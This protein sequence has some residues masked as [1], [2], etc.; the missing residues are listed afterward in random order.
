M[1]YI[2]KSLTGPTG[3][4][5]TC[6]RGIRGELS[7]QNSTGTLTLLGFKDSQALVGN[8][9]S[10]DCR[11]VTI[12]LSGLPNWSAFHTAFLSSV[13][14]V[15][16]LLAGGVPKQ[17][18]DPVIHYVECDLTAPTGHSS[19]VWT[20]I[21]GHI[22]I[23]TDTLNL[24]FAGY[25]D[26]ASLQAGLQVSDC[27]TTTVDLTTLPSWALFYADVVSYICGDGQLLENGTLKD[28]DDPV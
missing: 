14:G 20:G 5:N 23:L 13:C 12:A 22:E 11:T 9:T 25:K 21:S 27:R 3:H 2:D 4:A 19:T 10:A 24:T 8:C 18:T 26:A 6:W 1:L 7:I 15:G 16:G 17:T 28:T